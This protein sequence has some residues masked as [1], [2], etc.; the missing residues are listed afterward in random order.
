MYKCDR[1]KVQFRDHY[2]LN[3]HQNRLRPCKEPNT[4]NVCKGCNR[5][6]SRN[7]SLERHVAICKEKQTVTDASNNTNTIVGNNNTINNGTTNNV[8]INVIG[9]ERL[10]HI[11]ME[12]I[13]EIIRTINNEYQATDYYLKA[14]KLVTM[15]DQLMRE[16]PENQNVIVPT[17]RS[18]VGSQ[19]TP[20]GWVSTPVGELVDQAIKRTALQLHGLEPQLDQ[21]N[22]RVLQADRNRRTWATVGDLAHRGLRRTDGLPGERRSV[23]LAFRLGIVRNKR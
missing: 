18:L 17:L 23:R 15:F 8:T 16:L 6:F 19:H 22:N 2:N 4:S 13:V 9:K 20:T 10:D 1:C 21:H 7:D 12:R 5:S 3:R 14:G 11:P